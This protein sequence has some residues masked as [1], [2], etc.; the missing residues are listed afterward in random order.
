MTH[1]FIHYLLLCSVSATLMK[2]DFK[3]HQRTKK[4]AAQRCSDFIL[5]IIGESI[6]E[7]I[8]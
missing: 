6:H 2:L 4:T 7:N 3:C 8:I 5:I 1:S